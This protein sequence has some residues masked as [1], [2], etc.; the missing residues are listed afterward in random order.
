[1]KKGRKDEA[2]IEGPHSFTVPGT[3]ISVNPHKIPLVL[4]TRIFCFT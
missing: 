2:F 1:M 4:V 3:F